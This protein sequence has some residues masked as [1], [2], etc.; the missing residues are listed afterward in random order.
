MNLYALTRP[1]A[2]RPGP[3]RRG[4]VRDREYLAWIRQFSCVVCIPPSS[5]WWMPFC[6]STV[7]EAAHVGQ[8][9]LGQKCSDRETI[10]L[11]A[12]HHR[13][14][15]DSVHVLGKRFWPHHGLDRYR[16]IA[17]LNQRYPWEAA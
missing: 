16:L 8:R 5:N 13:N 7:S 1:R 14:G 2:R 4:R 11:C 6:G 15:R 10:P 9:G 3:P 17:E 12:E